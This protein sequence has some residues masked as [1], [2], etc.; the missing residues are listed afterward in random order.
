MSITKLKT[1]GQWGAVPTDLT[2]VRTREASR[3][4]TPL[5]DRLAGEDAGRACTEVAA[6]GLAA[7][8]GGRRV[9]TGMLTG[10][11]G[12]L[13]SPAPPLMARVAGTRPGTRK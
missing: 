4:W 11:D 10:S 3:N 5:V 7:Q 8:V 13:A 2:R 12:P 6:R 9:I 1:L